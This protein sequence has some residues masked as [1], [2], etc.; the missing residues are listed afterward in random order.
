MVAMSVFRLRLWRAST[1]TRSA[2]G[3]TASLVTGYATAGFGTTVGVFC[4]AVSGSVTT[5][6]RGPRGDPDQEQGD[7]HE[8]REE[9][10]ALGEVAGG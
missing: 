1:R 4:T 9:R 7:A 6:R 2:G 8:D 5:A 3:R 10:D